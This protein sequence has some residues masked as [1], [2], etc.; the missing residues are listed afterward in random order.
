[1]PDQ[2]GVFD[3]ILDVEDTQRLLH[4][5]KGLPTRNLAGLQGGLSYY[6]PRTRPVQP[7]RLESRNL[8]GHDVVEQERT[9]PAFRLQLEPTR[10]KP[11][12]GARPEFLVQP[13]DG[14]RIPEEA[15]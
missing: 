5:T 10:V 7:D 4:T 1:M 9:S 2:L 13:K 15:Q 6:L 12:I 8:P 14:F 3:G 11:P